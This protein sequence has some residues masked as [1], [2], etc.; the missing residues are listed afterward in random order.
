MGPRR[1]RVK[2]GNADHDRLDLP[3]TAIRRLRERVGAW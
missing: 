2:T 1:G 3:D